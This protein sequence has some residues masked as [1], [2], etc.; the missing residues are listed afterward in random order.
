MDKNLKIICGN[1]IE[2]LKKI[3]SKSINLIVTDPPYNLNK[4]YGNNKD[5]LE[6]EEYL[7]FSRQWLTEAKRILKDDGTIYIFMGMRYISYIYTI[8]EKELNMHFNSWI[9]WFYTQGIGKTKGFSPRHDD[10]L[11]FTKH[12]SKFTF[13]LDDIRVPQKFY[14]SINNMRGSN[15][16]NVWQF[17]HMHY[18]NKNRK[19]HP[20]QKPE[21][22]YERMILASSN[23][24]DIVLDPFVGSGTMLRVCQQTNRRAIGIEINEEYVQMCK[25]RLEEDFIGF[26]S[27][28]ERIKRVPNDLNDSSIRKEYL[29][30]HKKWFLKNHQNLIK[31]FEDEVNKKY[32]HKKAIR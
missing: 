27:G 31:K 8:L 6:F 16:G 13:N 24:N 20:T 18:C 28:D 14:R 5:N 12:K 22:L 26:D 1:A 10:I 23:E 29:E 19:K 4:D 21:G 9:T 3:E 7:E 11:M 17:S 2:E 30:N 15:P 32:F 25:E